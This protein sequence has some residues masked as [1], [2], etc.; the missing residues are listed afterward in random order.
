MR[1]FLKVW[2]YWRVML[3]WG[4][5]FAFLGSVVALFLPRE[6]SATAQI[7][8]VMRQQ[9]GID[10]YTQTK[11]AERVG[12]NLAA[13]V[14]TTD[15]YKQVMTSKYNFNRARWQKMT[16][17]KKRR[18]WQKDIIID[19]SPYGGV[20]SVTAL[21]VTPEDAVKL[22]EA[23]AKVII[24]YGWKYVGVNSTM[25]YVTTPLR[26]EWPSRPNFVVIAFMGFLTGVIVSGLWVAHYH[27][28]HWGIS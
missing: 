17:K 26:P 9:S 13:V 27:K 23:V 1:H 28:R 5:L 19:V 4:L 11:A 10:P 8:I 15:F 16:E 12:K 6:Y 18:R 3:A 24:D 21:S 22:A 7:L 25:K 20:V 2:R 14:H